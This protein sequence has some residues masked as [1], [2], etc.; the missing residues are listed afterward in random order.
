M[1][2][3]QHLAP[4]SLEFLNSKKCRNLFFYNSH[5]IIGSPWLCFIFYILRAIKDLALWLIKYKTTAWG[6]IKLKLLLFKGVLI[7]KWNKWILE[8]TCSDP[9]YHFI[10]K[11]LIYCLIC[12]VCP[13]RHKKRKEEDF[14]E[15]FDTFSC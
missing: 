5:R 13:G 10:E 12:D 4:L 6:D 2:D 11:S 15:T 14:M 9:N 1:H 3:Q 8:E 7:Y